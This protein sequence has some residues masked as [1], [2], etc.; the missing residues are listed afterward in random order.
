MNLTTLS[1]VKALLGRTP[2]ETTDDYT[3]R[4][5]IEA[6]SAFAER[7]LNRGVEQK[8]RTEYHD[9]YEEQTRVHL[10][11]YPVASIDGTGEGVWADSSWAYTSAVAAT[12]YAVAGDGTLY[13]RYRLSAVGPRA[14]KVIYIGG[15]A[16]SEEKM[17]ARYPDISEAVARQVLYLFNTRKH[18][19]ESLEGVSPASGWVRGDVG[20]LTGVKSVL[21]LYRC[22]VGA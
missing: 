9:L 18:V 8:T 3:L 21:D 6:V 5:L 11:G 4:A 19:G 22:V 17:V 12:N 14:L 20:W 2:T 10:F 13:F 7:Y 16:P 15:M 1:H